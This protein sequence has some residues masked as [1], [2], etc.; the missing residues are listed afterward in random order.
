[1][2][3]NAGAVFID[4][5]PNT[6]KFGKALTTQVTAAAKGSEAAAN[7]ST[8]AW[9]KFGQTIKEN[10]TLIGVVAAAGI[11]KFAQASIQAAVSAAS[12]TRSRV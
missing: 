8:S 11:A 1:M 10:A 3:I 6:T 5:L 7:Q 4:V 9:A 2:A 12:R